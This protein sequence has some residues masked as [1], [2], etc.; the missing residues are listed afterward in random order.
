[1]TDEFWRRSKTF[2]YYLIRPI[3]FSYY[4]LLFLSVKKVLGFN[5]I[6][7]GFCLDLPVGTA[8]IGGTFAYYMFVMDICFLMS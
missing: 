1:M 8:G 5:V 4:N 7:I 6:E 2:L 3:S